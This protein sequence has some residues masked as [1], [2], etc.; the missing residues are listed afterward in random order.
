MHDVLIGLAFIAMIFA[1]AVVA[2]KAGAASTTE[3]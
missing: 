3:E 2:A 1:P